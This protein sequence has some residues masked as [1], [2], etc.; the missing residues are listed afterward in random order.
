M[1]AETHRSGENILLPLVSTYNDIDDSF[2]APTDTH[3]AGKWVVAVPRSDIDGSAASQ[4]IP[5]V[6]FKYATIAH[7]QILIQR[8]STDTIH[9]QCRRADQRVR[10][11]LVGEERRNT[12]EQRHETSGSF[13]RDLSRPAARARLKTRRASASDTL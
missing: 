4:L 13:E 5:K 11:V 12:I 6:G 9:R 1:R 2:G 8:R 10:D 3:D 7:E